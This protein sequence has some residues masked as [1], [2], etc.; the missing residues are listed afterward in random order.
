MEWPRLGLRG[1]EEG[2]H[3]CEGSS[4][5]PSCWWG[6]GSQAPHL[7]PSRS[8]RSAGCSERST[9]TPIPHSPQVLER[10][11]FR[12]QAFL[13][14]S[15]LMGQSLWG[16][17]EGGRLSPQEVLGGPQGQLHGVAYAPPAPLHR[18]TF[19][20]GVLGCPAGSLCCPQPRV[21]GG[22]CPCC[23]SA[24]VHLH[25]AMCPWGPP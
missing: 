6:G 4:R 12:S 21:S 17:A 5:A 7:A 20:L 18:G 2:V 14:L 22:S 10:S 16:G 3:Q 9:P 15:L 8:R 23:P 1:P 19:G 11:L 25:S 13:R 24:Q